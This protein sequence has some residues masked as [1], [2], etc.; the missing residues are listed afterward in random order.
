MRIKLDI[1]CTPEE[2]R[3]F[4]GL[5]DVRGMQEQLL[6]EVEERMRAGVKA[7]DPE[8]MLKTL[9]A[10][11]DA[12][13]REVAGD[14][15]RP[16]GWREREE[17]A[18]MSGLAAKTV[19]LVRHG[20]TEWNRLKRYQGWLDSPLTPR[21][22][23]QAEA[24]GRLLRLLPQAAGAEIIAS[25]IGRARRTAEIIAECLSD[26]RGRPRPVRFDERLR[27]IS[28]GSWDGLDKREIRR[29]APELFAGEGGRWE[30]YF[31]TPDGETYDR[32]AGRIAAFLADLGPDPVI[33]VSH[34]IVTR[35]LRGLYA[36]LPRTEALR[37]AVPQDRVFR[38]CGGA[39]EEIAA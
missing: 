11:R 15:S 20:E 35:V 9:A 34:G 3:G 22:I 12:R 23:A 8:A 24:I 10:G 1:D 39:I 25:P 30:W 26:S 6:K 36:R 13:V 29:R 7:L 21:G 2:L 16:N 4:F 27:E 14:V 5:P 32:F 28:L 31:R 38:L 37:L 33:A 18:L 19:L 17:T